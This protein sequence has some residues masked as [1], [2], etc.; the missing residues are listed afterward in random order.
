M[1]GDADYDRIVKRH[2]GKV[3]NTHKETGM[4]PLV[5]DGQAL[6]AMSTDGIEMRKGCMK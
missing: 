4:K 1:P 6:G 5:M 2:V 3:I